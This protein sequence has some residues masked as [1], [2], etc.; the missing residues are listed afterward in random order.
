MLLGNK[1]INIDS[2]NDK[3]RTALHCASKCGNADALILLLEAGAD[4]TIVD[5]DNKT[6]LDYVEEKEFHKCMDPLSG[7]HIKDP[8]FD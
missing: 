6:A 5:N 3:G 7:I 1:L 4:D 8:G 2:Q